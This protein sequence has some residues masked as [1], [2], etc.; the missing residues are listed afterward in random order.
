MKDPA[1]HTQP[2]PKKNDHPPLWP[3][4]IMQFVKLDCYTPAVKARVASDMRARHLLGVERYGVPLQPFNGR[5][6][7]SDAYQEALDLRVYLEQ[8]RVEPAAL[9]VHSLVELAIA[10][11]DTAISRIAD[12]LMLREAAQG[13]DVQFCATSGDTTGGADPTSCS[14]SAHSEVE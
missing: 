2:D 7:L 9:A 14:G 10:S 13:A 3:S 12:A 6:G 11:A 8:V 1:T 4:V 5:D